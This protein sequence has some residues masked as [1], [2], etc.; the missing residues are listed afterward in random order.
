MKAIISGMKTL[1]V[2]SIIEVATIVL[3]HTQRMRQIE[4]EY[5]IAKKEMKYRFDIEM[6]SLENNMK[7]FKKMAKL[8]KRHFEIGHRERMELLGTIDKMASA[9]SSV[10]SPVIIRELNATITLLVGS[11][12][13]NLNSRVSFLENKAETQ[14]IGGQ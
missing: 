2:V 5:N 11:Y 1:P 6:K 9:I 8:Q 13:D 12:Q 4:N 3:Q 7:Q 10:K 14:L